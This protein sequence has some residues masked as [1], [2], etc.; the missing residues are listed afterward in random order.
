MRSGNPE[1]P[2]LF[3]DGSEELRT[4]PPQRLLKFLSTPSPQIRSVVCLSLSDR[5]HWYVSNQRSPDEATWVGV[6]RRLID[7]FMN[8]KDAQVRDCA[9]NALAMIPLVPTA[10]VEAVLDFVEGP[11][12]NDDQL[13]TIRISL[14]HKSVK[15][16]PDLV[17]RI[18]AYYR[19]W[20][21]SS[22]LEDRKA[23]FL[24]LRVEAPD[25]PVTLA[26]F[27][28]LMDAGDPDGIGS[29][30]GRWMLERHPS[31]IEPFLD[32]NAVQKRMMLERARAGTMLAYQMKPA[33]DDLFQRTLSLRKVDR[34]ASWLLD[35]KTPIEVVEEGLRVPELSAE[36]SRDADRR[37]KRTAGENGH[38]SSTLLGR[39]KTNEC[40]ACSS[41]AGRPPVAS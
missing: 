41:A 5:I 1:H 33:A 12:P 8:D 37:R 22:A 11:R 15:T 2:K 38:V 21:K 16:R 36:R 29:D 9:G 20:M 31:L 23:A 17:P 27:R 10:D 7:V 32:G 28:E 24:H 25:D 30:G 34:N 18:A 19:R 26:V 6:A 13:R 35:S 39:F 3:P 4:Y 14:I 40:P